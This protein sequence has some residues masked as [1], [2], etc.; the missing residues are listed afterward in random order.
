MPRM[1]A[2][3]A[4]TERKAAYASAAG[5][6]Q[7]HEHQDRHRKVPGQKKTR[8]R[9]RPGDA[10]QRGAR[11][12]ARA[13]WRTARPANG[14]ATRCGECARRVPA[15][16]AVPRAGLLFDHTSSSVNSHGRASSTSRLL[17]GEDRG[18]ELVLVGYPVG[19]ALAPG[20]RGNRGPR[21]VASAASRATTIGT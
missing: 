20:G 18:V 3:C 19:L 5:E 1:V 15:P 21:V 8:R 14:L 6:R 16:G 9:R 12:A 2:G 10:R 7:R 13:L 17:T 11:E 4:P